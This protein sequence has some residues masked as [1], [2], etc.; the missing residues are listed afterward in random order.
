MEHVGLGTDGGGGIPRFVQDYRDIR[1]LSQLVKAMQD[2]GFSRE[3]IS[4][5]MGGNTYRVLKACIG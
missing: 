5:Y 4:A 2:A 3:E 1:D